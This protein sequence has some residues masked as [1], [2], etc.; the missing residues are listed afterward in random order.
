MSHTDKFTEDNFSLLRSKI[1][2]LHPVHRASL[3]VLL[4]H[5]LH[6]SSHSDKNGMS[7]KEL[8]TRFGYYL[9]GGSEVC[10]SSSD[11]DL[12]V[13]CIALL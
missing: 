5:L 9:L 6:V 1:R 4:Q 2:K 3:E 11:L 12:K 13:R 10:E 8:S 7:V